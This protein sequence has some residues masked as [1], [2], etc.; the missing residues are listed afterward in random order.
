M[1]LQQLLTGVEYKLTQGSTTQNIDQIIYDSRIK[2]KDG[3][4]IAIK[5]FTSDGHQFINSAIDNGAKALIVEDD[6]EVINQNITIIKVADSRKVMAHVASNFYQNPSQ[7]FSL[8]G[9]TGTNGKTSSFS[10]QAADMLLSGTSVNH[11]VEAEQP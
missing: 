11:R 5:G 7:K 6:I 10:L 8:V 9:V 4:F 2:T 3:L 1:E